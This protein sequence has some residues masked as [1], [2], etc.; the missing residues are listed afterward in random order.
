MTRESLMKAVEF[1]REDLW[2]VRSR[3]LPRRQSILL[4]ILR[5]A[6]LTLR[7]V[8]EGR[9]MLRGS[10]LTYYS[11][12]SIVPVVAM[13][14][15]VAKGFGFEK[16]IEKVLYKYLA[17]Q[18]QVVVKVLEFARALLND[19]KGGLVAGIGLVILFYAIIKI[20]THIEDA[21][22]DIWGVKRGRGLGRK[23]SD[24]ISLMIIA[25]VLFIVSSTL[26][27]TI[28][29]SAR[30]IVEQITV[31]GAIGPVIFFLLSFLPYCAIWILFVFLYV[32]MPNTKVHLTS[33]LLAGIIAGT[34]YV[35]FQKV[36]VAFQIGMSRYNA[37]YGSFAALPLFFVWLQFSW[38][39]VLFGAE[40]SFAHQNVD[41]YEFEQDCLTVSHS[42]KRL[43]ALRIVHLLVQGFSKGEAPWT[44]GQI[45]R[46][47]EIPIR[48]IQQILSDLT[49]AGVI[50]E[51]C[52]DDN[53]SAAYQPARDPEDITLYS[54]V[55]ALDTLGSD[56]IPVAPS[57]QLEKIEESLAAF[58]E[59]VI[60]SPANRLLKEI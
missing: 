8:S 29:A 15:G 34:M 57:D 39:I 18:E 32:F 12:L 11:L 56:R 17:G 30:A 16:H 53:K 7:G 26:T 10:A 23:I 45:S 52:T 9:A 55:E 44:A 46:G 59:L 48:L 43:L 31:L 51:V 13:V 58:R 28:T 27:V 47:L 25:P 60:R 19:V 40:I 37:I 20:L 41:T 54:V 2:R 50:Q 38:L 36:Y 21:L 14:F 5:I 35:I 6:V 33:G 1:L 42:H 22:N 49:E 4:R 3:D 24:Y